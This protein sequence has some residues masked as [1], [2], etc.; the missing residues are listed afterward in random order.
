VV[1]DRKDRQWRSIVQKH[2]GSLLKPRLFF[3]LIGYSPDQVARRAPGQISP[4]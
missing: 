3:K 1:V 2:L 4:E